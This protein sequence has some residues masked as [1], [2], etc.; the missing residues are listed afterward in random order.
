MFL[1]AEEVRVAEKR[2]LFLKAISNLSL[3]SLPE[4]VPAEVG[5]INFISNKAY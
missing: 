1:W 3:T 5:C 4:P 2:F